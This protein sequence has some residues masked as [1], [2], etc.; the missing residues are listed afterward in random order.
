MA[1]RAALNEAEMGK[2]ALLFVKDKIRR[3]SIRLDP[4]E[5][6]RAIGNIANSDSAK[7]A[8]ISQEMALQFSTQILEEVFRGVLEGLSK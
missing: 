1:P 5:L 2:I 7:T 8:G 6:R 4:H 3:E